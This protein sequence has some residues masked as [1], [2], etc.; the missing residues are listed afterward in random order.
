MN[1]PARV[2]PA[3]L[4]FFWAASTVLLAGCPFEKD[5]GAPLAVKGGGAQ[6]EFGYS[7]TVYP[8]V[9]TNCVQCHG[10]SQ[11]PVFASS[12]LDTAYGL[13]FGLVNF[14]VIPAS[15]FVSKIKDGHC[16][17]ACTTDGTAMTALITQWKTYYGKNGTL[18]GAPVDTGN[19]FTNQLPIPPNPAG[20]VPTDGDPNN[21]AHN[22]LG[23]PDFAAGTTTL[24]DGTVITL[25]QS[26][27]W[28]K[29]TYPITQITPGLDPSLSRAT[30]VVDVAYEN[31]D[32]SLGPASYVFKNPRIISPDQP[33]YVHD[34][35]TF[36]D[37]T[38]HPEYGV[39]YQNIDMVV[40]P[41]TFGT[42]P[43]HNTPP[44]APFCNAL[45]PFPSA[46]DPGPNCAPG[47]APL[48]AASASASG[49]TSGY[50]ANNPDPTQAT[51]GTDTLGFSFEYLQKGITSQC[52]D[53]NTFYTQIYTPIHNGALLCLNCHKQGGEVSLAGQRFN[54]DPT[55][56]LVNPGTGFPTSLFDPAGNPGGMAVVCQRFLQRS[57]F[58][59]P[60]VSPIIVQ[61]AK[62]LNGMPAQ[63]NFTADFEDNWIGWIKREACL[64][65]TAN[66]A[67]CPAWAPSP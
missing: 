50:W 48:Y 45:T 23:S 47:V 40:A 41:A 56:T 9:R 49:I 13:A 16:G 5:P 37:G 46:Y 55:D 15:K 65:Q 20:C 8:Y 61:P 66:P 63:V 59:Y 39:L 60:E 34:V 4:L 29:L 24:A 17:G 36:V 25:Q 11:T 32:T 12:N 22:L 57:N 18:P 14:T 42:D 31:L 58:S 10:G 64:Q 51:H 2:A 7:Q 52:K 3:L 27:C 44:A 19:Y 67:S 6:G 54:M 1:R 38:Y 21:S 43:G 53:L 26:V 28:M 30:F 35:K 33:I 62:G